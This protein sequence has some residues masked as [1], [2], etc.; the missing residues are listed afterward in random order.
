MPAELELPSAEQQYGTSQ[1]G[2]E[3]DHIHVDCGR[4]GLFE[5][6]LK[7]RPH[8]TADYERCHLIY[9]LVSSVEQALPI[10]QALI[11]VF[12]IGRQILSFL[13]LLSITLCQDHN[14]IYFIA[15][16]KSMILTW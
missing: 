12:P 1:G 9:S 16:P 11:L 10:N 8:G 14:I 13:L 6:L 5:F 2:G 4:D 15:V 7:N 3:L